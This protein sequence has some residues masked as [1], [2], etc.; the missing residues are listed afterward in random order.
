MDTFFPQYAYSLLLK[1]A[2]VFNQVLQHII[3]HFI[4]ISATPYIYLF[5]PHVDNCSMEQL[6]LSA[7]LCL[8]RNVL[9]N[10]I[11][12]GFIDTWHISCE[13]S[14]SKKATFVADE[15]VNLI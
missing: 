13:N 11:Y 5:F 15:D 3:L 9:A 14:L 7:Q 1:T 6:P 4:Y 10:H 2:V 8:F 12:D